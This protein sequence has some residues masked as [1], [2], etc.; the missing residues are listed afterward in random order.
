M[1]DCDYLDRFRSDPDRYD[2]IGVI[3]I[4]CEL[5]DEPPLPIVSETTII[6]HR[7]AEPLARSQ[8][9]SLSRQNEAWV[10]HHDSDSWL[11]LC[12]SVP[13]YGQGLR[14]KGSQD[15]NEPALPRRDQTH[16]ARVVV[17]AGA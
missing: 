16:E 5:G 14:A 10:Q 12:E 2:G 9:P 1:Q 6:N 13:R 4:V 15:N 8:T 3:E 17:S 7:E 11:A